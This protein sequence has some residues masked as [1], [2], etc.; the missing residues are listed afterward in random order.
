VGFWVC[1]PLAVLS[2]TGVYIS[3]PQTSRALFGVAQP[4]PRGGA[5]PGRFAPPIPEPKLSLPQALAAAQAAAPG[6]AVVSINVPTRGKAPAWRI[7]LKAPGAERPRTIQVVDATGEVKTSGAGG[8]G[9]GPD[10][11]SR[12]MRQVHDGNEMGVV[13][14][15]IIFAGGMAPV[16]LSLTGVVMWL[17]RRRRRH[18][19]TPRPA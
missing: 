6:G 8:G 7:D 2:L 3:F 5:G 14:Q 10:P 12:L 9:G 11:L 13:W 4:A 18:A 17:R 15:T 19:L 1:I 16:V